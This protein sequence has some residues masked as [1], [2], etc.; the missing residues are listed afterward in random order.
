LAFVVKK[1]GVEQVLKGKHGLPIGK[2]AEAN[3]MLSDDTG[4]LYV[5][6]RLVA[7]K[8]KMTLNPDDI[9]ATTCYLGRGLGG[10]YFSGLVDSFGVYSVSLVDQAAPIP[11]PPEWLLEPAMVSDTGA[12]MQ[13]GEGCDSSRQIEYAFEET[14][15]NPGGDDSGWQNLPT[16]QDTGLTP[17]VKYA[18]RV[19]MRDKNG[20][21]TQASAVKEAAWTP[22]WAFIADSTNSGGTITVMEAEHYYQNVPGKHHKWILIDVAEGYGGEGAMY[23]SP[24]RGPGISN[25]LTQA[26]RLDYRVKLDKPGKY[27]VWIRGL[28]RYYYSNGVYVALD[29]MGARTLDTGWQ[30]P[31]Y[32]WM[33]TDKEKPF[34]IAAA[35]IHTL[36]IWMEKDATSVDRVLITTLSP[37]EYKPTGETDVDKSLVGKGPKESRIVDDGRIGSYSELRMEK[38]APRPAQWSS[39]TPVIIGGTRAV[40]QAFRSGTLQGDV[41]YLFEEV[42]GNPG[43]D[44]GSWQKEPRYEDTGLL[45]GQ[46]YVY[47][48]KARD[49]SG[50]ETDWSESVEVSTGPSEVFVQNDDGLA[51]MEAEHYSRKTKG[52]SG[53][54]WAL[55][56]TK[57]G[58]GG[59]GYMGA[60]KMDGVEFIATYPSWKARMDYDVAFGKTGP[61]WVWVR[62]TGVHWLH[63]SIR[64][65]L[66]LKEEPWGSDVGLW[67]TQYRWVRTDKF[68][69]ETPGVHAINIWMQEDGVVVDKILVTSD[70]NY[71]P[72]KELNADGVPG[73]LGPDE[74]PRK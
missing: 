17:G 16:Y 74:S 37:D 58:Y 2:W 45:P 56:K 47:R 5:D 29:D 72:S 51:V 62:G 6:G 65:G 12:V 4:M 26:P 3:L 33:S 13:A 24:E 71:V 22:S 36:S 25:Y 21:E 7:K 54:E 9:R 57:E 46:T 32:R 69:V 39:L 10:N 66:D 67:W 70:S 44:D 23:A 73:G 1:D 35:G 52:P 63:D 38:G 15:G 50:A 40:M 64:V 48:V 28:G 18:Y 55:N 43:G 11:N 14:T 61:H 30:G 60:E 20:N 53:H 8:D 68:T 41:E 49:S 42:T 34:E 27:H 19:K 59:D 31:K